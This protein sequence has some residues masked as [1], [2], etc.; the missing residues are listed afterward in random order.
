MLGGCT[1]STCMCPRCVLRGV[2]V[3]SLSAQVGGVG[4][5]EG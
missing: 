5:W 1:P 4:A 3:A 2:N